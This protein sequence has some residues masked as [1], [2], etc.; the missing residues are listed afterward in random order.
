LPD[1]LLAD[2]ANEQRR[3]D[4]FQQMNEFLNGQINQREKANRE[5]QDRIDLIQSEIDRR[6]SE[7]GSLEADVGKTQTSTA[8]HDFATGK[9][10]AAAAGKAGRM[11]E[12][13]GQYLITLEQ[14]ITRHQLSLQQAVNL[15]QAQNSNQNTAVKILEMHTGEINAVHARLSTLESQMRN[16]HFSSR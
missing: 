12:A 7:A 2:S 1:N 9:A 4:D 10:I 5:R 15:I 11:S 14:A 6:T 16:T 3:R 13:G 8:A